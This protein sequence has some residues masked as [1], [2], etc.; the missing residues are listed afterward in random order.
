M[1]C[2]MAQTNKAYVGGLVGSQRSKVELSEAV[3]DCSASR[4]RVIRGGTEKAI[5]CHCC[6]ARAADAGCCHGA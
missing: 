6:V 3:Q 4:I 5:L 2:R 1:Q